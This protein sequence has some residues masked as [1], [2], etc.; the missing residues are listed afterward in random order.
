MQINV[1]NYKFCTICA[2]SVHIV[3][4]NN[5]AADLAERPCTPTQVFSINL[6]DSTSAQVEVGRSNL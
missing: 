2:D 4:S 6:A 5:K 1:K 3:I